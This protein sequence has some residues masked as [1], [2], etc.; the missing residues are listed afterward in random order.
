MFIRSAVSVITA[1]SFSF[2]APAERIE[3]SIKIPA[4]P[5]KHKISLTARLLDIFQLVIKKLIKL[6][7]F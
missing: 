1:V 5:A 2:K 4:I 3:P 7:L 6:V